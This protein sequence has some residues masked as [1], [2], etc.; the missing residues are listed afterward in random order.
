MLKAFMSHRYVK[1]P[2]AINKTAHTCCMQKC[3]KNKIKVLKA[4]GKN[5]KKNKIQ[6]H[7]NRRNINVDR[8]TWHT[9]NKVENHK[10][11]HTNIRRLS[12]YVCMYVSIFHIYIKV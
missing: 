6:N 11:I 10:N 8:W 2:L 5:K 12:T 9:T 4:V 3:R 1:P 7:K